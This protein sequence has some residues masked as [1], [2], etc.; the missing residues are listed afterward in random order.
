MTSTVTICMDLECGLSNGE[1]D[2]EQTGS[3]A[4]L[5]GPLLAVDKQQDDRVV[6]AE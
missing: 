6:S 5:G 1:N 4:G 3:M 2:F